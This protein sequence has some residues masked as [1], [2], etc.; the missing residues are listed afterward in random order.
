MDEGDAEDLI[1]EEGD[2]SLLWPTLLFEYTDEHLSWNAAQGAADGHAAPLEAASLSSDPVTPEGLRAI[3]R[4]VQTSGQVDESVVEYL[5][6]NRV[7]SLWE[8]YSSEGGK[9]ARD[10]ACRG[11]GPFLSGDQETLSLRGCLR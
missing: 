7:C 2:L 6:A 9:S 3:D 11:R 4:L 10:A 5:V 1:R 8:R